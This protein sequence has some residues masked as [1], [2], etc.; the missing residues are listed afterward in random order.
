MN[1]VLVLDRYCVRLNSSLMVVSSREKCCLSAWPDLTGAVSLSQA[2]AELAELPKSHACES[3][4]VRPFLHSGLCVHTWACSTSSSAA[5]HWDRLRSLCFWEWDRTLVAP[6]QCM[7]HTLQPC[8]S[9]IGIFKVTLPDTKHISGSMNFSIACPRT[10]Y[11][12]CHSC[13]HVSQTVLATSWFYKK[14]LTQFDEAVNP[15]A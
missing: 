11:K 6:V 14:S 4:L 3:S 8:L 13:A 1:D 12:V 2:Q 10:L 9:G 7:S 5:L 15:S